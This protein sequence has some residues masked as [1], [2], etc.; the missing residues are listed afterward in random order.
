M[1]GFPQSVYRTLIV[2]KLDY[3]QDGKS[4]SRVIWFW[5]SIWGDPFVLNK[6]ISFEYWR[7]GSTEYRANLVPPTEYLQ[8]KGQLSTDTIITTKTIMR[9]F[10][11]KLA[12]EGFHWKLDCR[13]GRAF[14]GKM[15]ISSSPFCHCFYF[16]SLFVY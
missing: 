5:R 15:D 4:K 6:K 14:R 11:G 16:L 8:Y 9:V 2:Q 1:N 7:L 13:G 12:V 3:S 10:S